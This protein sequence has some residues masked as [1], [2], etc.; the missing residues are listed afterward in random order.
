MPSRAHSML[1]LRIGVGTLWG[2]VM[3][4]AGLA[5]VARYAPKYPGADFL[6]MT[7]VG[8]AASGMY[9]FTCVVADRLF[10]RA[11]TRL[12]GSVQVLLALLMVAGAICFGIF[13]V[14]GER[15]TL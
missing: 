11:D 14:R 1:A 3:I 5:V 10:P 4:I 2:A 12:C 15:G 13:F 7:G 9:V 8:L 6:R